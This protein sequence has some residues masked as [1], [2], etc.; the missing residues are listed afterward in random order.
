MVKLSCNFILSEDHQEIKG[1]VLEDYSTSGRKRPWRERKI[2][3]KLLA[4]TYLYLNKLTGIPDYKF[5]SIR[6]NECG[7]YLKFKEC[8]AG[9]REGQKLVSANFCRDRLCPLCQWRR[10][11]K[12]AYQVNT[13]CHL[14]LLEQP[15]LKFL[16][17][18]LTTKNVKAENL[19]AAIDQLNYAFKKLMNRKEVK[20][21]V[22]G[23]FK[24]IE[25]TYNSNRGDYHPHFHVILAVKPSYFQRYYYIRQSRWVELWKESLK[26]NYTPIVHIETI[27]ARKKGDK[28]QIEKDNEEYMRAMSRAVAETAKYS[29][30]PED[31]ISEDI[32]SVSNI[33]LTLSDALKGRRLISYGGILLE[34]RKKLN[35]DDLEGENVDLINITKEDEEEKCTCPICNSNLI[36]IVYTWRIGLKEYISQ[37]K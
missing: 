8:P 21:S 6:V 16:F 18:T 11:M 25:V 22:E 29:V 30:K 14:A 37:T 28:P 5:K 1:K 34:Q 10:A 23:Y 12:L 33:V 27:K 19:G 20:R 4:G 31:Y 13:V 36:D 32:K 35:M 9:H 3:S 2:Q 15:G 24:A 17:L 7:E 26:V